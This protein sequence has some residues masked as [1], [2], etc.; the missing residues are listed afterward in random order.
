MQG[1]EVLSTECQLLSDFK[2]CQKLYYFV[3]ES[4]SNLI[5]STALQEQN[6]LHKGELSVQIQITNILVIRIG[7]GRSRSV[8]SI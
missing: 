2:L 1:L 8:V 5:L 7:E 4:L 6:L 3:K